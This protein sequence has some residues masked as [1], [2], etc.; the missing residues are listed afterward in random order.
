MGFSTGLL[1][2]TYTAKILCCGMAPGGRQSFASSHT[3]LVFSEKNRGHDPLE[4]PLDVLRG[5]A[6]LGEPLAHSALHYG[7]WRAAGASGEQRASR[8]EQILRQVRIREQ[9]HDH[10]DMLP[11]ASPRVNS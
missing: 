8:G 3:L 1:V 6:Q 10:R 4:F 5:D 7:L 11:S 2:S 9:S